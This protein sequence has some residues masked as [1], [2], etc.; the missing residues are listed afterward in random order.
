MAYRK[1]TTR[2]FK[3][4][5]SLLNDQI[6]K[7]GESR[8]FAVSRVLTHWEEIVGPD[9]A[10]IAR[11]VKVGYGRGGLGATLTVLTTG[12]QA[13]MLEMQKE[14]LRAK[15]NGTYGYNA[16][17]RVHITQTAPTGFSEGHVDF[18]Y[19]PRTRSQPAPAPEDVAEAQASAAVVEN[20]ELR[21][22]L[23]RLG[24]NV[25]TRQKTKGKGY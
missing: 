5:S 21:A 15:V 1:S 8:G 12:A 6:R 20:D 2:G 24:Q 16:I 19:A 9:M 11:P 14:A 17:S 22:A 4:T 3:R 18:K 25:L 7:T 10:Q 13:P 23:E